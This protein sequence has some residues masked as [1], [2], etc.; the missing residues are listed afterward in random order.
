MEAALPDFLYRPGAEPR[1]DRPRSSVADDMELLAILDNGE[2]IKQRVVFIVNAMNALPGHSY[3][4]WAADCAR[5]P[6]R[7]A[8]QAYQGQDSRNDAASALMLLMLRPHLYGTAG[9][10]QGWTPWW[11]LGF[12]PPS[13]LLT[14]DQ[15]RIRSGRGPGNHRGNMLE[16]L[17]EHWRQH[18]GEEEALCAML[19]EEVW[20]LLDALIGLHRTLLNWSIE[21][22]PSWAM[23]HAM[24]V[25][26]L[27][28]Q[29]VP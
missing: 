17:I 8:A 26:K 7:V 14:L 29:L 6:V 21:E 23:L 5:D 4:A 15:T 3:P 24:L 22:V 9:V 28:G 11:R 19:L 13:S 27:K 20:A 25:L 10:D 1:G 2:E 18:G 16:G 12:P